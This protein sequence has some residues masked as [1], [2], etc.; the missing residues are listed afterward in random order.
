VKKKRKYFCPE[1]GTRGLNRPLG[2]RAEDVKYMGV[3]KM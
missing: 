1:T 3:F 2:G